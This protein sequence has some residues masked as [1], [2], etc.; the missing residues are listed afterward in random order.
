MIMGKLL[1]YSAPIT[2]DAG[3]YFN[4][5]NIQSLD[6][7]TKVNFVIV[8]ET[9]PTPIPL[10]ATVQMGKISG[11]TLSSWIDHFVVPVATPSPYLMI[12]TYN[13]I[14]PELNISLNG[15]K[16]TTYKIQAWAY[17]Q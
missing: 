9:P 17:L 5:T 8:V 2:T 3:G 6:G 12:K 15:M 13:V 16:N 4:L 11:S 7:F 1:S 14:G 10:T